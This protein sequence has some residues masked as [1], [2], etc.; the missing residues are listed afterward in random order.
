LKILIVHPSVPLYGG[1][2]RVIVRLAN[3][4]VSHGHSA[5]FIAWDTTPKEMLAD[6]A[7]EVTTVTIHDTKSKFGNIT[8]LHNAIIELQDSVDVI[9]V[10]N[11]PSS[12]S[13]WGINKPVVYNCNEPAE[14]FT[15]LSRKPV[16]WYHRYW[17]ARH[18]YSEAIVADEW[19]ADRYERLYGSYP[20][21]IPYGI[22][23]DF[24]SQ[25]G[26]N[27]VDTW[28]NVLQVGTISQYKH[29]MY[30]IQAVQRLQKTIPNIHLTLMGRAD[31]QYG[32]QVMKY[33]MQNH[34]GDSLVTV[35]P[36]SSAEAVRDA[37]SRAH[38][39]VHPV[40]R[41][42]GWLTPFEAISAKLPVI[43]SGL[44]TAKELIQ[45]NELGTVCSGL[46]PMLAIQMVH[47]NYARITEKTEKQAEWVRD[48][49]SW[50][51]YGEAIVKVFGGVK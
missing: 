29:Q 36:H 41:Q 39:L 4:L 10:H 35:I 11:F 16:E 24:F 3:Y 40:G 5:A 34:I 43:V 45:D 23:Y 1:A 12:L 44:F 17:I 22:D 19:Q 13:L 8:A 31:G 37:Y 46:N 49:L 9:N 18:V 2:E 32:N 28:F 50:D 33:I 14:V 27:R 6:F 25:A 48:N 42:G 20:E 7:K 30:S 26:N 21:I 38:V 47:D 51:K 15:S